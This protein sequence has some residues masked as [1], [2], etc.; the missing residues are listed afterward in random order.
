M[1]KKEAPMEKALFEKRYQLLNAKLEE[2]KNN[3]PEYKAYI[4]YLSD[5]KTELKDILKSK[6]KREQLEKLATQAKKALEND[7]KYLELENELNHHLEKN[8]HLFQETIIKN[9][10]KKD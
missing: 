3:I 10:N 1:S 2:C 9:L 4:K 8:F 7:K 6:A 5:N